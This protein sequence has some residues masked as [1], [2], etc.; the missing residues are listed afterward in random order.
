MNGWLGSGYFRC[1]PNQGL[2]RAWERRGTT[3]WTL[4]QANI[5][6]ISRPPSIWGCP[7]TEVVYLYKIGD[8]TYSG[9]DDIPFILA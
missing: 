6:S 7:V 2:S 1:L 9:S 5:E 3:G 8:E 4:Q